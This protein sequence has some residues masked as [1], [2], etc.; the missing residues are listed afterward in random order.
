MNQTTIFDAIL[1]D[2]DGTIGGDDTIHYPGSFE[3]S[4]IL[5]LALSV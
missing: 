2:R 3:C 5:I 4:L 1:I